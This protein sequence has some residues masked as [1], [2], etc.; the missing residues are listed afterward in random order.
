[1][2]NLLLILVIVILVA[3]SCNRKAIEEELNQKN[4]E[5]AKLASERDSILQQLSAAFEEF[6][7]T[8][9]ISDKQGELKER[10]AQSVEHLKSLLDENDR[11]QKSLQRRIAGSGAERNRLSARIDSLNDELNLKEEQISSM[12]K[13]IVTLKTQVDTQQLRINRLVAMNTN[14]NDVIQDVTTQINTGHI[15]V[16]NQ[17]ELL[18]KEVII[19]KGGFL[20][21]FGRVKKLNPQYKPDDFQIVDIRSD[22]IFELPGEKINIVTVHPIEAYNLV[23]SNNVTQLEITDPEKFWQASKYLVVENK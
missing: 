8:I 4:Q 14:Q 2:K 5:L 15:V 6:E 16:G 3:P 23:D 10:M 17:K 21:L 7:N 11:N 22:R 18:N 9:G 12:D 13:N 19:K 1:M 20:G